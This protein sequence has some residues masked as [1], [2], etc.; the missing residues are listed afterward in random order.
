MAECGLTFLGLINKKGRMIS[1]DVTDVKLDGQK[2][3]MFF[4]CNALIQ[5][6]NEDFDDEFGSVS[7]SV[8]ERKNYKFVT[9]PTTSGTLLA[10]MSK[11]QDHIPLL[12]ILK[13]HNIVFE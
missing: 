3:E 8:T 4:M 13:K 2:R 11:E 10:I 12:K 7:Y 1:S 6:L 5:R 9:V